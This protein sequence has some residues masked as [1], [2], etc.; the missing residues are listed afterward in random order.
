MLKLNKK[1]Q[2]NMT[3]KTTTLIVS[4]I[5]VVIFFAAAASLWTV[6]NNALGNITAADIPLVS[7]MTGIIGLVFGAV[8]LIGGLYM[9]IKQMQTR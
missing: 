7:S 6:L 4:V 5:G 1:G 9:L 8:V 2:S 3:N